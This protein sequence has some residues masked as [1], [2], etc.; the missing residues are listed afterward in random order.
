MRIRQR[1]N[2]RGICDRIFFFENM[3]HKT[4]KFG[5]QRK[6]LPSH[7]FV[8]ACDI[9]FLIDSWINGWSWAV[10]FRST[11]NF[12][13]FFHRPMMDGERGGDGRMWPIIEW[14]K[15][16]STKWLVESDEQD[17]LDFGGRV[18]RLQDSSR[19]CSSGCC[20]CC[21]FFFFLKIK[22]LLVL[23]YGIFDFF[24]TRTWRNSKPLDPFLT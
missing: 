1:A 24:H 6:G 2:S 10:D 11:C 3:F 18:P 7:D 23:L 14:Q 16:V 20:C 5:H 19:I 4:A 9:P 15:R 17:F 8:P 12:R 21:F 22:T 13:W